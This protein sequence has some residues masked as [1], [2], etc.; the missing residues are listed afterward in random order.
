MKIW[1]P[2]SLYKDHDNYDAKLFP[3]RQYTKAL[4]TVN[5]NVYFPDKFLLQQKFVILQFPIIPKI[6]WAVFEDTA[7]HCCLIWLD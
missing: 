6:N 3:K 4:T 2:W 1:S 7:I 5:K